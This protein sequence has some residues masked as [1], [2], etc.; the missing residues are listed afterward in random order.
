MFAKGKEHFPRE[1]VAAPVKGGR[2]FRQREQ[3]LFIT[4]TFADLKPPIQEFS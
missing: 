2:S 3:S 4:I 1:G